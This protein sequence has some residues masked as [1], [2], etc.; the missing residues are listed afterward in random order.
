MR[1]LRLRRCRRCRSCNGLRQ[2]GTPAA[3]KAQVKAEAKAEVPKKPEPLKVGF[4]YVSPIGDA[5]WT[6]QP[7]RAR[8]QMQQALG[9]KVTTS[10]VRRRCPKGRTPSA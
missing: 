8:E 2:A 9:D 10:F 1:M 3:P 4:V 5:G 6:T 7:N